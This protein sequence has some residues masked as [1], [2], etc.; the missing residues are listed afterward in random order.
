MSFTSSGG[1]KTSTATVSSGTSRSSR[2]LTLTVKYGSYSAGTVTVTQSGFTPSRASYSISTS[3]SWITTSRSGNTI[4]V[5]TSANNSNLS[6]SGTVSVSYAGTTKTISVSQEGGSLS[7]ISFSPAS[8]TVA[9]GGETFSVTA[10]CGNDVEGTT[11]WSVSENLSWVSISV[12]SNTHHNCTVSVTVKSSQGLT[13]S[14]YHKM[15]EICL[16]FVTAS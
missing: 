12:T 15:A 1:S 13:A 6:R 16:I 8:K 4:T 7:D 10:T 5:T 9:K 3:A 2:T 11:Y 14:F